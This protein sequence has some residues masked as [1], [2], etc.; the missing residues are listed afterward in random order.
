[1]DA[2][3]EGHGR[4]TAAKT[5]GVDLHPWKPSVILR[6]F[7][8]KGL[9]GGGAQDRCPFHGVRDAHPTAQLPRPRRHHGGSAARSCTTSVCVQVLV[10]FRASIAYAIVNEPLEPTALDGLMPVPD[11]PA[12]CDPQ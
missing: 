1:M 11:Q 7:T 5:I 8:D 4:V 2:P 12:W 10:P 3:R 6:L 9:Y